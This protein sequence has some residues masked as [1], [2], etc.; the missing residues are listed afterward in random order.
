MALAK[1]SFIL[2]KLKNQ[3]SCIINGGK[4]TKYFPLQRGA[5]QGNPVS[6]YLFILFLEVVFRLIKSSY[7]INGLKI[8]ELMFLYSAYADD[9]TFFV[10]D[11]DS[12]SE[13]FKVFD[14]FSIYSGL[15]PN[16]KKCEIADIESLKGVK[17]ALCEVNSIDLAQEMIKILGLH[18]SYNKKLGEEKNFVSHIKSIENLLKIWKMRTLSIE[19]KIN[20]FKALAISKIVHL[21]MV[22]DVPSDILQILVKMQDTFL[23]GDKPKIKHGTLCMDYS[24]GGLKKC[25]V[26]SKVQSLKLSWVSCLYDESKH[27]WK[28]LP[29]FYIHNF[30]GEDFQFQTNS[31]MHKFVLEKFTNFYKSLFQQW[32]FTFNSDLKAASCIASQQLWYNRFITINN[33]TVFF[34]KWS[35]SQLNVI[36]QLFDDKKLKP[37]NELRKEFSLANTDH[38]KYVQLCNAIPS[39]W[40]TSILIDSE[41]THRL[42]VYELHIVINQTIHHIF[43]LKAKFLYNFF[44]GKMECRPTAQRYFSNLFM[45]PDNFDWTKIYDLPRKTTVDTR[46]RVFQ[47]KILNNVL[48]LNEKLFHFGLVDSGKCSSCLVSNETQIHIF[49]ECSIVKELW[50]CLRDVFKDYVYLPNLSPQS[51]TLGFTSNIEN[52]IL[53][54]HIVLLFK[55]YVY[56]SRKD[57]NINILPFINF[58]T[59]VYDTEN[60]LSIKKNNLTEK[61]APIAAFFDLL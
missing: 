55:Y 26:V 43:K 49:S 27:A 4:I 19:G 10:G 44:L 3:E 53:I 1:I 48:Y 5:R 11:L 17:V 14:T 41:N 30:V 25:D 31:I 34:P 52:S 38:F 37:W 40:K 18:F 36:G 51:A 56:K 45:L 2:L 13:I 20:I 24:K 61:W 57:R 59:R 8:K 39:S 28:K 42:V 22:I 60:V 21:A 15:K 12:A 54:N 58:L 7:K 35:K 16:M 6:A 33:K 47:Y 29:N 50:N 9:T 32:S 23:W 46:L